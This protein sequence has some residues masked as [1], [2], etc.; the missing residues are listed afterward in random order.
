MTEV[1]ALVTGVQHARV[2]LDGQ[3]I[4]DRFVDWFVR[5]ADGAWR[6]RIA[7]DLPAYTES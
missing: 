4:D 7:L 3:Q 2:H 1:G 6:A 5:G